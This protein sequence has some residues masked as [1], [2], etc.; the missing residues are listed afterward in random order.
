MIVTYVTSFITGVKTR[1]T[2]QLHQMDFDPGSGINE[3]IPVPVLLMKI[4]NQTKRILELESQVEQ[5][6]K[7]PENKENVSRKETSS[8][9]EKKYAVLEKKYEA[10][11]Q[12]VERIKSSFEHA[13]IRTRKGSSWMHWDSSYSEEKIRLL[14]EYVSQLEKSKDEA[15]GKLLSFELEK[16]RAEVRDF[17]MAL[18]DSR[19]ELTAYQNK[20]ESLVGILK[21]MANILGCDDYEYGREE[22]L[23][24][25]LRSEKE[26]SKRLNNLALK[27][28]NLLDAA[29][30]ERDE[31][32]TVLESQ[33]EADSSFIGQLEKW[34]K[35]KNYLIIVWTKLE[36]IKSENLG[37]KK[38]LQDCFDTI[39]ITL[40]DCCNLLE[41]PENSRT[42]FHSLQEGIA[43][44][45]KLTL[46]QLEEN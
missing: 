3:S 23:L 27:A 26:K 2:L 16:S 44:L 40:K 36:S 25:S 35:L 28:K 24:E 46:S 21:I 7:S 4:S 13:K 10:K 18:S 33:N 29:I 11:C 43:L 19:I 39:S 34:P 20:L 31:L 32:M 15:T 1:K 45:S 41:I 22:L 9:L 38:E 37:L 42:S 8:S 12:E 30:C 17:K 6:E 14:E 5:L